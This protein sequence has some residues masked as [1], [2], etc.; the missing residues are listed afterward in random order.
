MLSD[1][2]TTAVASST[3]HE[4]PWNVV[5]T[6]AAAGGVGVGV[7][8]PDGA[9]L[10]RH[11]SDEEI[12]ESAHDVLVGGFGV[13]GEVAEEELVEVVPIGSHVDQV[14]CLHHLLHGS[15]EVHVRI[16]GVG[17]DGNAPRDGGFGLRRGVGGL[18]GGGGRGGGVDDGVGAARGGEEEALG[19]V[20]GGEVG[21]GGGFG[22]GVGVRVRGVI[23]V[24]HG[25]TVGLG[26][27]GGEVVDGV[28][29][30]NEGGP[31][32]GQWT[33][34]IVRLGHGEF[35]ALDPGEAEMEILAECGWH[36]IKNSE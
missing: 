4:S 26:G 24:V 32:G 21:G 2:R 8:V 34:V 27:G 33:A 20:D 13:E 35:W 14:T 25:A 16:R 31:G 28:E 12:C 7:G 5:A 9:A 18:G 22:F 10:W 30:L 17:G 11:E 6:A 29:V 23:V 19:G 15:P 1:E 36:F 3:L